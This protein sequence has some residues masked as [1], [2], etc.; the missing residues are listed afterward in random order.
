MRFIRT[1]I[2][3]L[4]AVLQL[5]SESYVREYAYNAGE[6]DSKATARKAALDAVKTRLRQALDRSLAGLEQEMVQ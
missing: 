6:N 4:L 1:G 2:L 5:H 3:F